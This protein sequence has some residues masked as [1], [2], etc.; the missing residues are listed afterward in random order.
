MYV[1]HGLQERCCGDWCLLVGLCGLETGKDTRWMVLCILPG[2]MGNI[3]NQPQEIW[4][5]GRYTRQ[6]I[7]FPPPYMTQQ[8]TCLS[9]ACSRLTFSES[10][11]FLFSCDGC[12]RGNREGICSRGKHLRSQ[13]ILTN[14]ETSRS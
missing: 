11:I 14:S 3:E 4:T 8:A 5:M 1:P 9:F 2:S 12:I 6:F 10:Y 7:S 13:L